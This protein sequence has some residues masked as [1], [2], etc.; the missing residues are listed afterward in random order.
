MPE[1]DQMR[2][3]C[4]VR[5]SLRAT[6]FQDLLWLHCRFI[7]FIPCILNLQFDAEFKGSGSTTTTSAAPTHS[8]ELAD[9]SPPS[10]SDVSELSEELL[11]EAL[12]ELLEQEKVQERRE[13]RTED[14]KPSPKKVRVV[15]NYPVLRYA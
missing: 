4:V 5:Q 1:T 7:H 2:G 14:K 11:S 8:E 15:V 9:G 13:P 3:M 12:S 6:N 10:V